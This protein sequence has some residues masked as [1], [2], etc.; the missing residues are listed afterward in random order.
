MLPAVMQA[1]R[2]GFSYHPERYLGCR[3]GVRFP[4]LGLNMVRSCLAR[5]RG[6]LPGGPEKKGETGRCLRHVA[7]SGN[8]I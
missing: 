1:V 7:Y 5:H 4:R 8:F 3:L 2:P 6:R